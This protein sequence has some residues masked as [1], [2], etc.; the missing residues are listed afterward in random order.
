MKRFSA[1]IVLVVVFASVVSGQSPS[2]SQS[3]PDTVEWLVPALHTNKRQTS[4]E[5]EAGR[6][7]G[8]ALPAPEILQPMLDSSIPAYQPR[9]DS[10]VSGKLTGAVS[11]TLPALMKRWIAA[12]RKYYPS[13]EIQVS[14][15]YD[16]NF[17]AK[18]LVKG[19]LDF[20]IVSR[21]LRPDDIASFKARYGYTPLSLPVAAGSY[22]QFGFLDTIGFFVNRENPLE[23]LSFDQL[24]A[25]LSST[26]N[27][28]GPGLT[29]WGQLGLGGD[30]ADKPIHIYGIKPWDGGEDLIRQK[31]LSRD[32]KRGEW[33]DDIKFDT[34]FPIA[35]RVSEDRYGIGFT[36]LAYIDA[37]VRMVGISENANGPLVAPTY[38]NV[39]HNVY[40]FSRLV[41]FNVNRPPGKPLNPLLAE[42]LRFILSREGQ[43]IVLDHAIF[44][45]LRGEQV[46]ESRRMAE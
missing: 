29:R 44:L 31:V 11:D 43:Q 22:R 19:T 17:G 8:R 39:A 33:R 15:P 6:L 2:A 23:G 12:F 13:V 20:V 37:P 18:E 14:P 25:V 42:F 4:E 3:R 34:V 7:S 45:P 10:Q 5:E 21:V 46:A 1:A 41:Y 36:G 26:H 30:W 27:R 40:P 16:S 24:D 35:R 28:G 9:R 32:G 38:E